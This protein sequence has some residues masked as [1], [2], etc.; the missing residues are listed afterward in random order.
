MSC[1]MATQDCR[2]CRL[3]HRSLIL[4]SL[5]LSMDLVAAPLNLLS[6]GNVYTE[7]A[8]C[9]SWRRALSASE[10]VVLRPRNA[11]LVEWREPR[12]VCEIVLHCQ[13]PSDAISVE[14]W[15]RIWPDNGT[16]G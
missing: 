10:P 3:P 9:Q 13:S 2:C 7:H 5:L 11:L 6:T 4:A 1:S 14:W 12:E 15:H 8:G 16:G